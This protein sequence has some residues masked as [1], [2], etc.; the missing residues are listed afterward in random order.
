MPISRLKPDLEACEPIFSSAASRPATAPVL[1]HSGGQDELVLSL[2]WCCIRFN[3]GGQTKP[4][5]VVLPG[6][7]PALVMEHVEGRKAFMSLSA[8]FV[9]LVNACLGVVLAAHTI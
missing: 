3:P 2:G 6:L 9:A 8:D 4:R 5:R 1:C 7:G